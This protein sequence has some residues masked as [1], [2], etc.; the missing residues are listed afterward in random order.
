MKTYS[1]DIQL[2]EKGDRVITPN[3]E[4]T[5]TVSEEYSDDSGF[6]LR[7]RD[8]LVQLDEGYCNNTINE[9]EEHDG[10][11]IIPII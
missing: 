4:G 11:M 5:V 6:V 3:G 2:F 9:V 10:W 7:F 1:F 8:V